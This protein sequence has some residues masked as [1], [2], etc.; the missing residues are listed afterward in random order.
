MRIQF[1]FDDASLEDLQV[2]ELI[3]KY[4]FEDRTTFFFP[5]MPS[6]VNEYKGRISLNDKQQQGIAEIFEIGS[7]T[8][9]H[10][11]LTRIPLEEAWKEI[12]DS[13]VLLKQKFS[14]DINQFCYPRGYSNPEIQSLV[15]KAGYESAR[16][17][18]VG[19]IH[20]TENRY[21]QQTTVHV[22]C[23]RKEYGGK[24]WFNYS[25]HMLELAKHTKNSVFH[26][27]GHGYE[28]KE[29]GAMKDFEELLRIMSDV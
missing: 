4:G 29:N 26:A 15:V 27:W 9:T 24:N 21:F 10:Q 11:L 13:R 7:H 8:M 12:R 18:L 17:T 28:I 1:S 16:S 23:D 20:E 6:L 5:A 22:G 14:Q 19:Y 25:L 3:I 2:A